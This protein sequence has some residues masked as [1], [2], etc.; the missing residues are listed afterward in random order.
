[1]GKELNTNFLS[2]LRNEKFIRLVRQSDNPFELLE[3]LQA[4]YPDGAPMLA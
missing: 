2:L 4:R 1:M 3:R